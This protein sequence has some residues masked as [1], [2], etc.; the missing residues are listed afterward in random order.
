MPDISGWKVYDELKNNPKWEN[1][2]IIF[3]TARSDKIA[4]DTGSFLGDD[5][6]EKPFDAQSLINKIEFIIENKNTN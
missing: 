1:I 3:L 2:K 5:F 4:K 6:I